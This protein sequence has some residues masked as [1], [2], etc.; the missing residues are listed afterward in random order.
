M[1]IEYIEATMSKARYELINDAEPYYGRVPELEG[2]WATGNA[3]RM[4]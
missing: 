3:G 4:P 2:V 1:I